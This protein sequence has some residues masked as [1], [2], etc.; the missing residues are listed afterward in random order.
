MDKK[1]KQLPNLSGQLLVFGGVYSNFQALDALYEY[2]KVKGFQAQNI[3]C[4][5]DVVAYCS[6]PQEC[7][8][9]IRNWGIHCISGNVE[10][11]LA[12]GAD[13]CGC[14]FE[15]DSRCD[16]FSR[17]WYPF[18][19]ENCSEESII[20]MKELPDFLKFN[21]NDRR[22]GVV[23]GTYDE[24]AG[25]I[26]NSSNWKLKEAQLKKMDVDIILAGHCGIPFSTINENHAWLNS[27]AIGMPANDG[28]DRVWFMTL[29]E[30]GERIMVQ[31]HSLEYD[32]HEPSARMR[33]AKLPQEYA[34]TLLTGIWDSNEI[35]PEK[36]TNQQGVPLLLD[37][38]SIEL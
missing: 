24:T 23:H 31:H 13:D 1:I 9:L 8:D 2:A 28:T 15:G 18:A 37:L 35:L 19:K 6:Q 27:G 29:E 36:E 14:N 25:Y 5:G 38:H 10:I 4:T 3:I 30:K 26:F 7:I 11:Q 33:E 20:W 21:Y 16:I 34:R 22:F 12:T 17:Q 32:T